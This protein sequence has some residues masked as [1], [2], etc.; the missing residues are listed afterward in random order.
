MIMQLMSLTLEIIYY[1]LEQ[2]TST[3]FLTTEHVLRT[4]IWKISIIGITTFILNLIASIMNCFFTFL[5]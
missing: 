1:I 3:E 4:Y 2:T 5:R